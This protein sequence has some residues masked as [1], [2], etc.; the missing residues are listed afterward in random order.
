MKTFYLA[1]CL[2][3]C[4]SIGLQAQTPNRTNLKAGPL[5]STFWGDIDRGE[6]VFEPRQSFSAGVE[7]SFAIS[8]ILALQVEAVYARKGARTVEIERQSGYA[9]NYD[10]DYIELPLLISLTAPSDG[11]LQGRVYLGPYL[12]GLLRE[13]VSGTFNGAPIPELLDHLRP[14]KGFMPFDGGAIIGGGVLFFISQTTAL[15]LDVRFSM[16][17]VPL[18]EEIIEFAGNRAF[19][20]SLGLTL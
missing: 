12:A 11:A 15:S 7:M 9:I 5:F 14:D 2:V 16:G 1:F 6:V 4:C 18:A 10:L 8:R 19:G 3:V 20:F 13:E 17:F